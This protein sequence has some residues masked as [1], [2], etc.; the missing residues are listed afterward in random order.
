MV[1]LGFSAELGR[2][3]VKLSGPN[4]DKLV[5]ICRD[6]RCH[7]EA[8]VET[9]GGVWPGC[10]TFTRG[11]LPDVIK[12]INEV[13][14][15]DPDTS[16][17]GIENRSL[18]PEETEYVRR[19]LDS[20][21]FREPPYGDYQR[22]DVLKLIR[23]NRYYLAYDM[24]LGKT[25]TIITAY[26][27][28][29]KWG[30]IDRLLVIAPPESVYNFKNEL[31]RFSLF[32]TDESK[33]YV[34]D[35]ENR[36]PFS[37]DVTVAIM[38]YNTFRM[39]VEDEYYETHDKKKRKGKDGKAH[40][41]KPKP[42]GPM[43][44][45]EAWGRVGLVC[46]E[47]HAL[48][49]IDSSQTR[50]VLLNR[51]SFTH[52]YLLSGTPA[53]NSVA[54]WYP[55]VKLLDASLVDPDY[56]SW[57]EDVAVLGTKWSDTAPRYFRPERVKTFLD[58]ISP[59]VIRRFNEVDLPPL[60]IDPIFIGMNQKHRLL[61]EAL[62]V[63]ALAVIKRENNGELVPK[64]VAE[65]FPYITQMLDDPCLLDGKID[66]EFSSVLYNIVKRWKFS[67]NSKIE[68]FDSL[69]EKYIDDQQKQIIIWGGHPASLDRLAERYAQYEPTVIH[70]QRLV[71]CTW[72]R[73]TNE[74]AV[75][76]FKNDNQGKYDAVERFKHRPNKK[77][78]IASYLVLGSAINVT[79]AKRQ[80]F[81]DRSW[82]LTYW[83]QSP[84]R[85]HRIGQTESVFINPIV[86]EKTLSYLQHETLERRV[87]LNRFMFDRKSLEPGRWR[88]IF[89]GS[90]NPEE[91]LAK[92]L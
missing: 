26:N 72:N 29:F 20:S 43:A 23:Q 42:T 49:N 71:E 2:F 75:E 5:E 53:P 55:Q 59:W 73:I 30:D 50:Y 66:P 90:V 48:G 9:D 19:S 67:D 45:L 77:M 60:I 87:D 86:I 10:W 35:A 13:E 58:K 39:L 12:K 81:W 33:I 47:A 64:K 7:F 44:A 80:L 24:G 15:F 88:E 27:H 76:T 36:E 32:A 69:V 18:S 52:R 34:A 83:L 78:L 6:L 68:A 61:Y 41:I 22:I 14:R 82:S 1:A 79:Q 70:G 54:Q 8:V 31:L 3:L 92:R 84:K 85:S 57:L 63:D 16:P 21:C 46:D 37:L 91:L 65:K 28:F 74:T 25:Y 89:L 51:T 62:T 56:I 17:F 38:T 40:K 4:F 11:Q